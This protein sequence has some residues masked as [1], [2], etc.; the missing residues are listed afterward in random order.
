MKQ[1]IS[2]LFVL[3]GTQYFKEVAEHQTGRYLSCEGLF[4]ADWEYAY[5]LCEEWD[6][7]QSRALEMR[8][9]GTP[10]FMVWI[11]SKTKWVH[12]TDMLDTSKY[13]KRITFW[14]LPRAE[15]IPCS[16]MKWSSFSDCIALILPQPFVDHVTY[17]QGVVKICLS[18]MGPS[19]E[20]MFMWCVCSCTVKHFCF[21]VCFSRVKNYSNKTHQ[22]CSYMSWRPLG[23]A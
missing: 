19:T 21:K 15:N 9:T 14:F 3:Y 12:S 5:H 23:G 13:T 7:L 17:F 20:E 22:V 2:P 8:Q 6:L 4:L 10:L 18:Q 11:E 1:I 16:F